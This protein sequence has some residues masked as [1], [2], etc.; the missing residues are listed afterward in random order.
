M[1]TLYRTRFI[2]HRPAERELYKLNR[3]KPIGLNHT[4]SFLNTLYWAFVVYKLS[5]PIVYRQVES[6]SSKYAFAQALREVR[7]LMC[8][9][10]E[11]SAATRYETSCSQQL[12]LRWK[13]LSHKSI[14]Y[15]EEEQSTYTYHDTG[16]TGSRAQSLCAVWYGRDT[17]S[18]Y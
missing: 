2:R 7:F 14:S 4:T 10:S 13:E 15:N 9:S 17:W 8:Q 11:Q 18:C 5:L 16:S 12:R 1:F 3:L 6:M